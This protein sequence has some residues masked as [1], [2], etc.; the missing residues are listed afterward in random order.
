MT[1]KYFEYFCGGRNSQIIKEAGIKYTASFDFKSSG[2]LSNIC[3][4]LYPRGI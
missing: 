3:K 1:E 2:L 4:S